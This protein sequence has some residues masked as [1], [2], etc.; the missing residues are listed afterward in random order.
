M[1]A[2]KRPAKITPNVFQP[3]FRRRGRQLK[4]SRHAAP[5]S[6]QLLSL[7][8]SALTLLSMR[9]QPAHE[10]F[11]RGPVQQ[12]KDH[13]GHCGADESAYGDFEKEAEENAD[14][15]ACHKRK[16]DLPSWPNLPFHLLPPIPIVP[17]RPRKTKRKPE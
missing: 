7:F 1:Q 16:R 9:I 11:R 13:M 14:D 17:A 15:H 5:L 3:R 10:R 2:K 4:P 6:S 8:Y 12:F